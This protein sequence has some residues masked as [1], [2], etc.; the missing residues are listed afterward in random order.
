MTKSRPRERCL[1]PC[2][3]NP[4]TGGDG[5]A[6]ARVILKAE[7]RGEGFGR[8]GRGIWSVCAFAVAWQESMA[9]LVFRQFASG[10][11]RRAFFR[12]WF[13][14]PPLIGK[15]CANLRLLGELADFGGNRLNKYLYDR[16]ESSR[17]ARISETETEYAGYYPSHHKKKTGI[18]Q[19][20]HGGN[21]GESALL[22]FAAG[23][24]KAHGAECAVGGE[25]FR[26]SGADCHQS[27][28]PI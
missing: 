13:G 27:K 20:G 25:F 2:G 17:R 26:Q 9:R 15:G 11:C 24:R 21:M 3:R 7:K 8:I 6:A 5:L 4:S 18:G 12:E 1:F 19:K 22:A 28:H 10:V 16:V 23:G 14:C